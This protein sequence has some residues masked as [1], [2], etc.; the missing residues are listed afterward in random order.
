MT[1]PTTTTLPTAAELPVT[2]DQV[3]EI[4]GQVWD[5]FL[6]LT[7]EPTPSEDRPGGD[8]MCGVVAISGAWQGSVVLR[9][10]TEH[11]TEAAEAMFAADAGTLE[12][13]EVA[14]ALGELTNMIGGNIKS[15]LPEPS[16]L[17][18]PSVS[19]GTGHVFVPGARPVLEVG[20]RCGASPVLVTVWQA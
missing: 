10:S 7:L 9:C 18:I 13:S 6:G 20:M 5:S 4:A 15:L 16:A 17:S 12:E 19:G 3:T 14:D 1:P 11:A 8:V 2:G